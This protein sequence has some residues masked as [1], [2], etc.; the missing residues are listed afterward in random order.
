MNSKLSQKDMMTHIKLSAE[1]RL[2][3][4]FYRGFFIFKFFYEYKKI[5][6]SSSN[7]LFDWSFA[8]RVFRLSNVI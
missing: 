2:E 6:Y 7:W 8:I 4:L 3:S 5:Y 1:H